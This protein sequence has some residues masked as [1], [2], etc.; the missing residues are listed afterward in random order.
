MKIVYWG[1]YIGNVGTIKSVVNSAVSMKKYGNHDVT[2]IKNHSEW[3]GY[4]EKI[5]RNGVQIH[6]F[7]LKGFLPNLTKVTLMGNRVYMVVVAF[8]GF[9]QFRSYLKKKRPDVVITNLIALPA[10]LA[11]FSVRNRPKLIASIQG[12][13]KFLGVDNRKDYPLWMRCE[14]K[15]RKNLWNLFYK[16]ADAIVCMTRATRKKLLADTKLNPNR[17][18]VIENPIVDEDIFQYSEESLDDD[19]FTNGQSFRCVAIG[20]YTFQKDFASLVQA[21][22]ILSMKIN[23][24]VA[25]LGEGEDRKELQ[26]LIDDLYLN[27]NVKLYGF[28]NNPYNYLKNSDLFILSSRWEDPSH[29]ILEAAALGVPIVSTDCPSG[30]AILLG[31]GEGGELCRVED[32]SDLAEKVYKLLYDEDKW[33]KAKVA[34]ENAQSYTLRAHFDRLTRMIEGVE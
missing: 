4:E 1:P 31:G 10:I 18:Y 15:I 22:S 24:K 20:R 3:E 12:F 13:P 19:W 17:M 8:L 6:D 33:M 28:V 34:Y 27:E 32:P 23:V 2:I 5:E 25:I 21:V 9:F 7:G 16:K 26:K 30:P 29:T 11:S 14:D